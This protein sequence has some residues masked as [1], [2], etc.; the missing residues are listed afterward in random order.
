M[1]EYRV[2]KKT[3]ALVEIFEN[4]TIKANNIEEAQEKAEEKNVNLKK[5]KISIGSVEDIEATVY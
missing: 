4:I 3:V 2:A 5:A 1:K